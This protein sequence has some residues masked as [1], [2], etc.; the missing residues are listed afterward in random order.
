M[1]GFLLDKISSTQENHLMSSELMGID[2]VKRLPDAP[3]GYATGT[4]DADSGERSRRKMAARSRTAM[5]CR[6]RAMLGAF[7]V[8]IAQ[9]W[10]QAADQGDSL[11]REFTATERTESGLVEDQLTYSLSWD[12]WKEDKTG[13]K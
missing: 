1:D 11:N 2:C 12:R 3:N 13:T 9:V 6:A 7:L 5:G 10:C 4:E 8:G